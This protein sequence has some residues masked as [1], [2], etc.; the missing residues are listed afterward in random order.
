MNTT[1]SNKSLSARRRQIGRKVLL[2]ERVSKLLEADKRAQTKPSRLR[3]RLNKK[4]AVVTGV[5]LVVALVGGAAGYQQYARKVSA[6][7][8]ADMVKQQ[9]ALKAKSEAADECRQKKAEQKAHLIGKITY[10]EL[11]DYGECDK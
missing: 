3:F 6:A 9:K 4:L 2:A 1:V 8:F 11:Y 5:I 7:K 10:D